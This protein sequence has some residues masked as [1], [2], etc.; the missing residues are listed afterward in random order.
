MQ[1]PQIGELDLM[2]EEAP[3]PI[4]AVLRRRLRVSELGERP[5]LAAIDRDLRRERGWR[6]QMRDKET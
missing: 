5:I 3:A 4:A 1:L 2:L 6:E